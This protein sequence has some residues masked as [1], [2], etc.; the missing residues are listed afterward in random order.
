MSVSGGST[1]DVIQHDPQEA[2]KSGDSPPSLPC[3][4][5]EGDDGT[6]TKDEAPVPSPASQDG[7]DGQDSSRETPNKA[8]QETT[9]E[10]PTAPEAIC[11][12]ETKDSASGEGG[13]VEDKVEEGT[14]DSGCRSQEKSVTCED[15]KKVEEKTLEVNI[16]GEVASAFAEVKSEFKT[17]FKDVHSELCSAVHE[18]KDELSQVLISSTQSM[19][20]A[21][22]QV[23]KEQTEGKVDIEG[24]IITPGSDFKPP[25]DHSSFKEAMTAENETVVGEQERHIV[26]SEEPHGSEWKEAVPKEAKPVQHPEGAKRR[27]GCVNIEDRINENSLCYSESGTL[28]Q[29]PERF[30]TEN[31]L[32]KVCAGDEGQQTR[33]GGDSEGLATESQEGNQDKLGDQKSYKEFESQMTDKQKEEHGIRDQPLSAPSTPIPPAAGHS[34]KSIRLQGCRD[35]RV[36][37]PE[38][39]TRLISSYLEPVNP[40]QQMSGVTVEQIA[41][42]YRSSCERHRTQPLPTVVQQIKALPLGVGGRVECLS[43][44]GQRL[45]GSQCEGLEEIFR[46]VQFKILDLEGC[47]LDDDTAIPLFDMIEFYDSATQLNISCNAKIGFRGWQACSRMLKRTPSVEYL[48]ARNTNLNETNMPIL[49]RA[50]RLGARLHTLHLE[51]CN[52]T[53][54]PLI[55]LTAALKHNDTLAEL[56]LAENRLGVNDCIQLGNLVRANNTLRLLDLRNNNVQDAGCGHVCEGIAEQQMQ[57]LQETENT[58]AKGLHSLVLWNNHLT[59]QSAAHLANMLNVTTVLET[60][61]LGRNNLTSEGILRLKESL[62]R[63]HALLRLGL[64]AARVADEGAVALAE[65]TADNTA[66]QHIDLRENPIR[67]AGL[68]ALAHSLRLNSTIIQMDLDSDPRTEPAVELA[69]QH[70]M[71][72]KE[73]KEYCQRNLTRSHI[74][75]SEVQ[76]KDNSQDSSRSHSPNEGLATCI[77]KISLTCETSTKTTIAEKIEGPILEEE[78]PKYTSPEPSPLPSP[79]PSPCASPSPSPVPSPLKNRFRVIRVQETSKGPIQSPVGSCHSA[80]LCSS[81][82]AT[83]TGRSMSSGDLSSLPKQASVRPNRFSIGGRFTV[84]RVVESS[85]PSGSCSLPS[86]HTK[87]PTTQAT[88]PVPGT[89]TAEGPKIVISS[90]IRVER[91]FS[92]DGITTSVIPKQVLQQAEKFTST[93]PVSDQNKNVFDSDSLPAVQAGPQPPSGVHVR[94]KSDSSDGD[95]VFLDSPCLAS[96]GRCSVVCKSGCDSRNM[97]KDAD[98]VSSCD[99]TDSGFLDEGVCGR[100]GVSPSPSLSS[101]NPEGDRDS[102][103]SSSVDSTSQ[104][105]TGLGSSIEGNSNN[106]SPG[107]LPSPTPLSSCN[108]PKSDKLQLAEPLKRAPL[109][110]MENGSFDSDSEDSE[111]TTQSSDSTH[112][113]EVRITTEQYSP[114]PAWETKQEQVNVAKTSESSIVTS[115]TSSGT[116]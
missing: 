31:D 116:C 46:R 22:D 52:L 94:L 30:E 80:G 48:D 103:L 64:Q 114:R 74:K 76:V 91:G 7:Q 49:G 26:I 11:E 45:D 112:S 90:P 66:I 97:D 69:E 100:G 106:N 102:L 78:K 108:L 18:I 55:M 13:C 8:P 88:C 4:G 70:T 77:R 82:P 38:D 27:S 115:G 3:L 17:A 84:T 53:G 83:P 105:D 96:N 73:I 23:I 107:S 62:L 113:D 34:R 109:A 85:A 36:S 111:V 65:Y 92:V 104:E 57:Q 40:W 72:Q 56:Y 6:G 101:P 15:V 42:A 16:A 32:V 63:N 75:A 110:S 61:N 43:L 19:S 29:N 21:S 20:G 35:R 2:E 25:V 28:F 81:A 59:Q 93:E 1:T 51:N 39:D 87:V 37:F 9:Q 89:T 5:A 68:M 12:G 67:V 86:S 24:N 54:R 60:L 44:R 41:A 33:D 99:L 98:S 14:H 95:D 50:L 79:S 71:L 10:C 47:S 58:K